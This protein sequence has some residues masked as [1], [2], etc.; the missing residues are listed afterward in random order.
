MSE[1]EQTERWVVRRLEELPAHPDPSGRLWFPIRNALEIDAFGINAWRAGKA[2]GPLIDEHDELESGTSGHEE[3]Y[4]VLDGHATFVVDGERV[5]APAGTLVFVRDPA[6][7]RAATAT[8]AGTTVLAV[9]AKVGEAF[10]PSVWEPSAAA[11][12]FW[13]TREFDKAIDVFAALHAEHPEHATVLYNLACAES[14]GGRTDDA[15]AHLERAIELNPPFREAAQ[16]DADFDPIR[17]DPRFPQ[18]E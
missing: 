6:A 1:P 15:L 8:E 12:R 7:R 5:D 2:G 3:L 10:A 16:A 14:L 17:A 4:A 9:G 13:T 11:L 18:P